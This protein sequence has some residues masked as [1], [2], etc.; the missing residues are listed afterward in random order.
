MTAEDKEL[1]IHYL[2]EQGHSWDEIER[3]LGKLE[4]WDERSIRESVFDSIEHG[5]FNLSAIIKEALDEN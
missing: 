4:D 3:V 1:M 5:T 2:T